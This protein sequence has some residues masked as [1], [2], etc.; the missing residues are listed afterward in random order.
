MQISL[1]KI[2]QIV[3]GVQ[4]PKQAVGMALTALERK[5]PQT[6]QSIRSMI[7]AGKDP[8]QAIMEFAKQGKIQKSDLPVIKN[9]AQSLKNKGFS[10]FD[11]SDD[12]FVKAEQAFDKAA[13]QPKTNG[14]F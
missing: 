11:I 4:N 8:S 3:N 12:V 1:S 2:L 7:S 10:K 9:L 5:D 13:A 6:A 14:W